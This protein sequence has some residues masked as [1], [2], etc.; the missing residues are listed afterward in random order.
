M[1]PQEFRPGDVVKHKS[2]QNSPYLTITSI[3]AGVVICT[4]LLRT[5]EIKTQSFSIDDLE[6]VTDGPT[7]ESD[8]NCLGIF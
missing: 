8:I 3:D 2:F 4:Y 6:R 7:Y 1:V 5:A